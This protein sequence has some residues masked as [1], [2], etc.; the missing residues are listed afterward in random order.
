[1]YVKDDLE[2]MATMVNSRNG[3]SQMDGI[4]RF[5]SVIIFFSFSLHKTFFFRV[6]TH[7]RQGP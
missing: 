3:T 1:M 6:L 4:F 7:P 5:I 2:V